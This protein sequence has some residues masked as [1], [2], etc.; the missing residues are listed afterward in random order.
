MKNYFLVYSYVN[1]FGQ[2]VD[3]VWGCVDS[4]D[5]SFICTSTSKSLSQLEEDIKINVAKYALDGVV[6]TQVMTDEE[7]YKNKYQINSP[8][9][10]TKE[11][12]FYLLECLPPEKWINNSSFEIFRF[13]ECVAANFYTFCVFH[14]DKNKYYEIIADRQ[15]DYNDLYMMC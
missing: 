11:R 15:I 10:V 5:D 8:V 9:E 12:F 1:S 6:K 7:Y 2:L 14:K 13:V 4:L 3:N